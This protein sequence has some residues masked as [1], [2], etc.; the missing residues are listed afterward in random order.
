MNGFLLILKHAGKFT[1]VSGIGNIFMILG[2]MSIASLVT[3]IGFLLIENWPSI[4]EALDSPIL[5]LLIIFMI[6]YVVG[7]VFISVFSV[8]SNTILQCFLVDTD[9]SDQEGKG[10]GAKHRPPA[11]EAFIYLAKKDE[12]KSNA[13][14]NHTSN[15][16]L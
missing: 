5:P 10:A 3:L 8:T 6:G 16:M 2:K 1:L 7:A 9:I 14:I 11:L 15:R 4:E 12:F 13:A